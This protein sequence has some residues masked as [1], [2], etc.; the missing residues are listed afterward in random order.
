MPVRPPGAVGAP[1]PVRFRHDDAAYLQL[2][3]LCQACIRDGESYELCLTNQATV[4]AAVDPL[5]LY[6][7]LRRRSPTA[8]AA[9]LDLGEFQV[10]SSS[11]E[12]FLRVDGQLVQVQLQAVRPRLLDQPGVAQPAALGRAVERADHRH[13]HG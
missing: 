11:M 3:D 12:R 7:E 1:P 13:R 6:R 9:Y 5:A 4:E 8:Y 2:I 10:L